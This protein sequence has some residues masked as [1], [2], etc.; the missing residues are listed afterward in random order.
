MEQKNKF[1]TFDTTDE[2]DKMLFQYYENKNDDIPLSTKDAIE[3]AFKDKHTDNKAS[4]IIMLKRVA[5]FILSF[6]IITVTTVY[7]KDI[8]NFITSIFTN[9]NPGIDK[10]I[11]NGY[12]Q[13]VDMDFI[14]YNNV[15][16]KVDYVLMDDHNLDISFVYKYFD[17]DITLNNITFTDI[18]I[19]D[20]NNNILYNICSN[21][22]ANTDL[23]I[24]YEY[25]SLK[26][27]PEYLDTS[28]LKN[29]LLVTSS[30]FPRSHILY[31][32]ISRIDV[33]LND[34]T[35]H[36]D[37][38]WNFSINLENKFVYRSTS[39]YNVTNNDYIDNVL[40]NLT[41]T[42]LMIELQ[43]NTVLNNTYVLKRGN[44][45]LLDSN[46]TN[47]SY[48]QISSGNN[49]DTTKAYT[50]IIKLTYPITAYDNTDNLYLHIEL[51]E[52]K[53]IDLELLKK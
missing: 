31:I 53:T 23:D 42:S 25:S 1:E 41:D 10:A 39:E 9:S 51:D 22:L 28:T 48:T 43:L 29:S 30:N 19:K 34:S 45:T 50:S 33:K 47:Y 4:T 36:I 44:I 14:K 37:G 35:K 2:F 40:T 32:N 46:N 38:N 6:G 18:T 20:E 8:V 52:N 7:A 27:E 21:N 26:A 17:E 49:I 13:N 3:N 16:V 15:G 11:D 12:I 5:I 24:I